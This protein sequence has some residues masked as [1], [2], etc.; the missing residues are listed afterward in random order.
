MGERAFEEEATDDDLAAMRAELDATRCGPARSGSRR[1]AREH[2]ETS[3]DRPVASRLASWDEVCALV[4]VL[5]EL[6]AGDLPDGHRP[7]GAR[8]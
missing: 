7:R 1:R 2:H 4:D 6:G 3:D 5:G 8:R